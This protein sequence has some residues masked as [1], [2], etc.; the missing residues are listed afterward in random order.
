[1]A[2]IRSK[3]ISTKVSEEEYAQLVALAGTQTISEWVRTVLLKAAK[4]SGAE[5]A[6]L[7][8]LL[9]LRT[10]VVNL[11]FSLAQGQTLS[12]EDMQRLIERADQSKFDKARQRLEHV[13]GGSK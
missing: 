4:L 3:S 7:A 10:I 11:H 9:A 12:T 2:S 5:Q 1:M 6:I 8:E 13:A